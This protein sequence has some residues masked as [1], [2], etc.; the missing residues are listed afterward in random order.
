MPEEIIEECNLREK[1]TEEGF[2]YVDVWKG[3]Y[4]LPQAG[5]LAQQLVEDRLN[6]KRYK[7]SP[8]IPGLWVHEWRPIQFTV[9][10][11][12]FGM[13]YV[14]EEHTQH[15]VSVLNDHYDITTD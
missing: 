6:D 10:V 8:I 3:V 15:L 4:G 1:A 13:K 7:Q 11:D 12:D 9:V 5:L 14:G 2:V